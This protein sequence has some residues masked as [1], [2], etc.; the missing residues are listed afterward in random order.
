MI[1]KLWIARESDKSLYLFSEKPIFEEGCWVEKSGYG[2]CFTELP[3]DVF[4]EVTFENSPKE[5]ELKLVES[6]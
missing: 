1:M 2:Y 4:P 5:V 3:Y 6:L